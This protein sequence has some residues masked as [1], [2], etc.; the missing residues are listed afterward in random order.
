MR[1]AACSGGRASR[2]RADADQLS[3]SHRRQAQVQAQAQALTRTLDRS[4]A[5]H[6][7]ARWP[8]RWVVRASSVARRAAPRVSLASRG[9]GPCDLARAGAFRSSFAGVPFVPPAQDSPPSSS[10][11]QRC[12]RSRHSS[13]KPGVWPTERSNAEQPKHLRSEDTIALH[14]TIRSI[15]CA[16]CIPQSRR[17]RQARQFANVGSGRRK[18]RYVRLGAV[19]R[20]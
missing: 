13:Q 16:L 17:Q 2:A 6:R 8:R 7:A 15:P 3:R 19:N 14:R 4:V 20:S 12:E 1:S 18:N 5:N 10:S 9:L 11:R